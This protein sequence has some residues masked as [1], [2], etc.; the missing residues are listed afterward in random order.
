M[1]QLMLM[2]ILHVP[3][4]WLMR[5]R[6]MAVAQKALA[7]N[8]DLGAQLQATQQELTAAQDRCAKLPELEGRHS[9]RWAQC[10][11]RP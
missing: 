10:V 7:D 11:H 1:P 8:Q 4:A 5:G 9:L 3:T 6:T 2:Q